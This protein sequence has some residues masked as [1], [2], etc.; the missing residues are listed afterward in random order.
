MIQ[1]QAKVYRDG[2]SYSVEFPDIPG[3]FSA[4]QTKEEAIQNAR[5]ALSLFLEEARDSNW[6]IPTAKARRSKGWLWIT[7]HFDIAIPLTIRLARLESGLTQRELAQR[8]G[9]TFQQL[10]KLETPGKSNPT[11][12]TLAAISKALERELSIDLVA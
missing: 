4:G 7:P 3:C 8:L 1:Y 2:N 11:V 6:E 10:Q 9:I 12:K 5:D